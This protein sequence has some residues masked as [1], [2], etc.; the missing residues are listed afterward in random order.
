MT[1]AITILHEDLFKLPLD[2]RIRLAQ[3]LWDSVAEEQN[4]MP[5]TQAQKT[6]LDK[7]LANYHAECER[8]PKRLARDAIAEI[9]RTL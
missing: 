7:R 1:G 2:E 5:V 6:E 3:D 4:L 9:R 8:N